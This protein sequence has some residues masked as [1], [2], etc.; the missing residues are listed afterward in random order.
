VLEALVKAGALDGLGENR[1][2]L[3]AG[4]ADT[5]A[6]AERSAHAMAAG[7]ATSVRR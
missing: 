1:A 3:M 7:Q 5:L 2:T 6:M 4:I